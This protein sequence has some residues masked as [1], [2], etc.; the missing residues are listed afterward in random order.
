MLSLVH[1]PLRFVTYGVMYVSQRPTSMK[2]LLS[3][4]LRPFTL[5][6]EY[7]KLW[8]GQT[9]SALTDKITSMVL[10][11]LVL[12]RTGSATKA[13]VGLLLEMIPALVLGPVAGVILDRVERKRVLVFSDLARTLAGLTMAYAFYA[14]HF[15]LF[16]V[17]GWMTLNGI[18]K[19]FYDAA[20]NAVI[21]MVVERESIQAAN[22]VHTLGKNTAMILGP[23]LGGVALSRL[24]GTWTLAVG[25]VAFSAAA[26]C[27]W[28][29]RP[30]F[31]DRAGPSAMR[32]GLSEALEG[33]RFYKTVPLAMH[34]LILTVMVNLCTMPS[35][36]AFQYH[37]LNVL[38]KDSDV[39]G[40]AFSVAAVASSI[41]SY[42]IA[43]RGRMKRLGSTLALGIAA[44]ALSFVG[45]G[46][47]RQVWQVFAAFALFGG[48]TPFIQV[49]ISTLYQEIT[50]PEIRGRVFALRFTVS[51]FLSPVSTPL[52]GI[53]LDAMGSTAVLLVLAAVLGAVSVGAL[54]RG[55][56]REA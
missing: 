30:V 16:H 4:L 33:F 19:A 3:A 13:S 40:F 54:A 12:Q 48:S 11:I 47:S 17:Y 53:G 15:G 35:G 34:L 39:L 6:H 24:G 21:P 5:G 56:V 18:I 42:F 22:A 31:E 9:L 43:A 36:L 46:V 52:V 2:R 29:I 27:M 51:T 8:G 1:L 26:G 37:V 38:K 45:I 28:F 55:T 49:P 41:T 14:G 7:S 20:T 50:P 32:P 23:A 10:S 25:A 44:L